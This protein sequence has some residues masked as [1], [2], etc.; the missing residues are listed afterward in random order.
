M[1][2]FV[3]SDDKMERARQEATILALK[4]TGQTSVAY[5]L[6]K[7]LGYERRQKLAEKFVGKE[8]IKQARTILLPHEEEQKRAKKLIDAAIGTTSTD[9]L[10]DAVDKLYKA[11]PNKTEGYKAV[12]EQLKSHLSDKLPGKIGLDDRYFD[13][14]LIAAN[15]GTVPAK[16]GVKGREMMD[17]LQEIIDK[18][19]LKQD[20][21]DK[22]KGE[23]EAEEKARTLI[24]E[25]RFRGQNGGV[26][27]IEKP[28]WVRIYEK[29]AQ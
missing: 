2:G 13:E 10:K 21:M 7:E 3:Q 28:K 27:Y 15:R 11:H 19:E 9:Q 18:P 23:Y 25:T 16:S 24:N 14:F 12:M 8:S 17:R 29:H 22:L 5:S 4:L 1:E 20:L 6:N 26:L